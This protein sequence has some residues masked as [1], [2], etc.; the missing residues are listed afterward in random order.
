VL[1]GTGLGVLPE[2][3]QQIV[4]KTVPKIEDHQVI[5]EPFLAK[6]TINLIAG[7]GKARNLFGEASMKFRDQIGDWLLIVR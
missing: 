3:F 5:S 6:F 1:T 7:I 4:R 2:A